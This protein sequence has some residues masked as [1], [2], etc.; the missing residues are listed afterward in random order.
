MIPVDSIQIGILDDVSSEN[1]LCECIVRGLRPS[2]SFCSISEYFNLNIPSLVSDQTILP[3]FYN[4]RCLPFTHP[5]PSHL[6][7]LASQ[8]PRYHKPINHL[9]LSHNP[10]SASDQP[11]SLFL[12]FF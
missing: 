1:L 6:L 10:F 4:S 8:L 2:L 5:S 3:L 12:G 11:S 7:A 9:T